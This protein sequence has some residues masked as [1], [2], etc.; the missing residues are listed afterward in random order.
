MQILGVTRLLG[1]IIQRFRPYEINEERQPQ[2][3][4]ELAARRQY[5]FKV[6]NQS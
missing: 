6:I 5:H 3:N 2:S 1:D 4:D